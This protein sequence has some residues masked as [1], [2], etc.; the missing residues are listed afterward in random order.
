MKTKD[1]LKQDWVKKE[2]IN[3]LNYD[4]DTGSLTWSENPRPNFNRDIIGKEVGYSWVANGYTHHNLTL[5]IRGKRFNTSVG[6]I[7][8]L[9][10]TGDW[11]KYTI[12]HIDR[13]PLNNKWSNL[14]DI[15]IEDNN[16]NKGFYKGRVFKYVVF[17]R[18]FW[19]VRFKDNYFGRDVCLGKAVKKRDEI[20]KDHFNG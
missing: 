15:T 5:Q 2:I 6:R 13:N 19:E 3:R 4:P 11:P 8:W 9:F 12:D 14:R 7:C 17:R 10:H 20:L 18:G 16:R 1:F